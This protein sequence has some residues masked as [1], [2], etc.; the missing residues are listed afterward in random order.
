VR[1]RFPLILLLVIGCGSTP[2]PKSCLDH[3]CSDPNLPFCDTDGSIGGEPNK[4]IAVDC[5]PNQFEECRGDRA[6]TCND[7][8]DNYD[9]LAC[10]YGC[11]ASGCSP[12]TTTDC[13]KRIAPKYVQTACS[14]VSAAPSYV[15]S[16]N[17]TVNTNDDA[18]CNAIVSQPSGLEIC[19]LKYNNIT[20][21]TNQTL[22]VT[23]ARA[24]A[25]VADYA[26]KVEGTI[27]VSANGVV[28]GPGGGTRRSGMTS[29]S[30]G[31]GGAGYRMKGGAGGDLVGDGN[32]AN[33]GDPQM[34]P[35]LTSDLLGG[36]KNTQLTGTSLPGGAGGAVTLVACRGK[37][38]VAGVVDAGGGGGNAGAAGTLGGN[39]KH[40]AGGGS[41]GTIAL[42]GLQ[43]DVTGRLYANGGA[44]GGGGTSVVGG[45]SASSGQDAQRSLMAAIGGV[46][47]SI[48]GRV[49]GH[50]GVHAGVGFAGGGPNTR[51]GA[52][53]G[54]AGYI[55]VFSPEFILPTLNPVEVSPMIEARQVVPTN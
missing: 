5:N 47:D 1:V 17:T 42:Q 35:L 27:D 23:G 26:L 38:S 31:A 8:G 3:H 7:A 22:T 16:Q 41:G 48:N 52:G 2:N 51:P 11:G 32:A 40:P 37:L 53:G 15:I 24:L 25:L 12:C 54:S 29:T 21:N 13:E 49:G 10:E 28:D 30:V 34:S 39:Y 20:I 9:L 33:G 50:G 44:G 55:I 18:S 6:V 4:C 14:A 19:L 43:V 36:T 46:G 45:T